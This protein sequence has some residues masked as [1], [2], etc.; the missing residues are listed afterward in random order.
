V[1][2]QLGGLARFR[3][4][5]Q[6][7]ERR[8]AAEGAVVGVTFAETLPRMYHDRRYIELD[9][10]GAQPKDPRWPGYLVSS[11]SVGLNYF[12]VLA[13]PI[14][15]GRGFQAADLTRDARVVIV[16]ESFV[17]LVLGGRNPIGRRLRRLQVDEMGMT[18]ATGKPPWPWYEIIGVV[19]DL[20][21][22]HAPDPK[23]AGFYEPAA[24]GSVY[25]VQLAVHVRGDALSFAPRLRAIAA[26][27]DPALRLESPT[28]V[29]Q[30][31][32]GEL[33]F[34]AFWFKLTVL[35]SAVA[36]LLSLAGIY[37]V[38]SFAVSRRMREIGIR[39]AL[40][41]NR[42]RVIASTFSRPLA[43][44]GTGIVAGGALA[45]TLSFLILGGAIWPLG[46]IAV[47]GYAALM[48]A[49]CSLACIV[50]TRRALRIQPTDALRAET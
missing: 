20:G 1:L 46:A 38:T 28:P 9:D 25:P 37:S 14:L 43:Q 10:G 35:V 3:A 7:L 48:M 42:R 27:V 32:R 22:S 4:A 50:P 12:D 47:A 29:S 36:M 17:R 23:V 19:R 16:N 45:A 31:N 33:V 18:V 44:V 6:E 5:H 49:V 15:M 26:T 34:I 8:L 41:A 2:P 40:G 39:V 13:A 30:L 11:A 24:T 21:M